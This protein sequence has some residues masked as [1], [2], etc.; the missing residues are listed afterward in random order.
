VAATS[1]LASPTPSCQNLS[2]LCGAEILT[3]RCKGVR[4]S[5]RQPTTISTRWNSLISV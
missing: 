5:G 3:T 1:Y 4:S 2:T